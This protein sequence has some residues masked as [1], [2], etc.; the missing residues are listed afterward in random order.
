MIMN[1]S[2]TPQKPK[3][4][5]AIATPSYQNLIRNTLGDPERAKRFVA[6]ITSAVAVNPA[7][8]ECET[9]SILAGALLG[10][11]L[12]LSPSPQLGQFYLVPFDITLKD[13]NGK[14]LKDENG[15]LIKEKRAS[16][17]LGYK[18]YVQLALRS[19]YYKYL[20]V[21][22]VKAGEFISF[23]PFTEELVC[24]WI[25]DYEQRNA[26]ETIGYA[27][28]FE[29]LN[30]YRKNLY[31]TKKRMLLHAN[32]YSPAFSADAY[33][34]IQRG[35]IPNDE[36]WKYSSFW[37]KDFDDMAKKTMLRQLIGRWGVMSTELS[38]AYERDNSTNCFDASG[39]V[40]DDSQIN[41]NIIYPGTRIAAEASDVVEK[42]DL[43]NV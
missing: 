12:N 20:N 6:T 35:E 2:N 14:T 11:S 28:T 40:V 9:G 10:E 17:V 13:K 19:G 41:A 31:W 8:Q 22:E 18:G 29:Y 7:L 34:K 36:M 38:V 16:F 4:S 21:I 27:A 39:N 3:F 23:N 30:G 43:N 5:V 24:S 42:I 37:Y 25:T 33:E 1:S 32:K 26:A 15:K